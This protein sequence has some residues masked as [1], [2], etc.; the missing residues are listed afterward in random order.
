VQGR[1]GHGHRRA[2]LRDELGNELVPDY[3][4]SVQDGGLYGWSNSYYGQHVDT[5][6]QPPR[7]DLVARVTPQ[8][9]SAEV[10]Q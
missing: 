3:M 4:S 1:A 6:V 10:K 7:P 8:A 2:E 9:K 5:R